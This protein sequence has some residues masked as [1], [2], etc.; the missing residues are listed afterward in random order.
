VKIG[1]IPVNLVERL[2]LALGLVPAP[3]IEAWFSFMLARPGG[4]DLRHSTTPK[5]SEKPRTK[6]IGPRS[7]GCRIEIDPTDTIAGRDPAYLTV[8]FHYPEGERE[9]KN[10]V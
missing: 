3:A 1:I 9:A 10:Q 2:A 7:D 8:V 5:A 4:R 6:R